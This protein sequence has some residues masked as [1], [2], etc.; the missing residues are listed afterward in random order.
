V[1]ERREAARRLGD[2][3]RSVLTRSL[4][5]L[6]DAS[7]VARLFVGR[8]EERAV[9][10]DRLRDGEKTRGGALGIGSAQADRAII[11]DA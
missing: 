1:R 7:W 10:V 9:A 8:E 2:E 5:E 4:Q 3:D 6:T 11:L